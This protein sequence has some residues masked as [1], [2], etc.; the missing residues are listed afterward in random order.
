MRAKEAGQVV[1]TV[2]ETMRREGEMQAE[3]IRGSRRKKRKGWK[4]DEPFSSFVTRKRRLN[5]VTL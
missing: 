1:S 4:R 3:A 5:S 2:C